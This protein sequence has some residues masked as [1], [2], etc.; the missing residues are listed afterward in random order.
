MA[1]VVD[2][3]RS[4]EHVFDNP[5]FRLSEPGLR[6]V[7]GEWLRGGVVAIV[8]RA[9]AEPIDTH[10]RCSFEAKAGAR[11]ESDSTVATDDKEQQPA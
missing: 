8:P 2:A 10:P 6:Q 5:G 1:I 4:I 11:L 9:G 7:G 3:D